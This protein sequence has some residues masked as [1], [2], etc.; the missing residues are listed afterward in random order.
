[1]SRIDCR[2]LVRLFLAGLLLSTNLL[3]ASVCST[4]CSMRSTFAWNS[5]GLIGYTARN[6]LN[7]MSANA[8]IAI[9]LPITLDKCVQMELILNSKPHAEASLI[10]VTSGWQNFGVVSDCTPN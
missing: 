4:T 2:V 9:V 1:M 8:L 10:N 5:G 6:L 7:V 3:F